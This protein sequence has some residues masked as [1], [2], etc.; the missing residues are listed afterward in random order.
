MARID[1]LTCV[2]ESN[3][4]V[5]QKKDIMSIT[6]E[7]PCVSNIKEANRKSYSAVS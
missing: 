7:K 1:K 5:H 3:T 4:Q 2:L 6:D